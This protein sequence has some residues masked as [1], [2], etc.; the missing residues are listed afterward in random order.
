MA[1]KLAV[2]TRGATG[3]ARATTL[4]FAEEGTPVSIFRIQ[5]HEWRKTV[6]MIRNAGGE[7]AC[8]HAKATRDKEINASFDAALEAFGPYN[9]QC[10]H[11]CTIILK[12]FLET[13]EEEYNCL[14][15]VNTKSAFMTYRRVVLDMSAN[16]HRVPSLPPLR[17]PPSLA[18]HYNGSITCPSGSRLTN[19]QLYAVQRRC[20][21]ATL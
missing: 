7:A 20:M 2:I 10:N 14:V 19:D 18:M 9:V 12:P 5:A 8:F 4:T 15:D 11:A 1:G 13:T 3:I 21:V 6:Q 16:D 17:P